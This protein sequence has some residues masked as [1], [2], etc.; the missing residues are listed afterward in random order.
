MADT[1]RAF[2]WFAIVATAAS[3]AIFAVLGNFGALNAAF[4]S[5]VP[6]HDDVSAGVHHLSGILVL[7]LSCD[8]LSVETETISGTDYLLAFQSWQDP[9]VTC[10]QTP[11]SRAFEAVV[12]ASSNGVSFIATLNGNGFPITITSSTATSTYP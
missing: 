1:I 7:P 8:E 6:I 2:V 11:T 9:S 10:T 4:E 5:P 3:F 12:P